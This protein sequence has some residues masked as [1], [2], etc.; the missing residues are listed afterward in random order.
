MSFQTTFRVKKANAST[1]IVKMYGVDF[2][3]GMTALQ[4]ELFCIKWGGKW[5]MA[6]VPVGAGLLHHCREAHRLLWPDRYWH[7]WTD[8]KYS[9]FIKNTGVLRARPIP[10]QG[11]GAHVA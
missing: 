4:R 1:A 10:D 2:P 3:S 11:I 5:E 9:N 7:R 8:L 6:G